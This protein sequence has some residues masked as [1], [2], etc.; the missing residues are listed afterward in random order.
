M[1][2]HNFQDLTLPNEKLNSIYR[3]IVEDNDDPL[4][5]GRCRIRV[6]G[7]H[8]NNKNEDL[9]DGIP[10][11]NLIW[12]QPC[13]P[14]FGGI[15]KTG[16]FGIPN[17]GSHVFLFFENGNIMQPRYFASI[18][19]I[20]NIP[21]NGKYGFS[22]PNEIY[23]DILG[24]TDWN[25]DE[26][27]SLNYKDSFIISDKSKNII[28]LNSTEN[29]EHVIIEHGKRKTNITLDKNGNLIQNIPNTK[30]TNV[31]DIKI[32]STGNKMETISG[33]TVEVTS[34]YK[35]TITG[36]ENKQVFGDSNVLISGTENKKTSDL[37]W[38]IKGTTTIISA[39]ETNI[40]TE[41]NLNIKSNLKDVK[42]EAKAKNIEL[43]SKLGQLKG[44]SMTINMEAT[45][46]STLKG[47]I[48]TT[49]GGGITTKV[50]GTL[51]TVS[52]SAIVQI[53]GGIIMIG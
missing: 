46:T 2:K 34:N 6:I 5:S 4:K 9:T 21:P 26:D 16:I 27:I 28:S 8:T 29:E 3:G 11:E 39:D 36:N 43:L 18:P 42:I 38:N 24:D 7:I 31:K 48:Q 14:I 25:Y 44:E 22:D 33:D 10:T 19:G 20:P 12:S 15:S 49:V 30:I 37:S 41:N 45:L 32:I 13:I 1:N 35:Q 47:N 53:T 51:T 50:D 40:S 23:P 52:G 17:I